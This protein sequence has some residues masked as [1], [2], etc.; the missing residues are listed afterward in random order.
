M[1]RRVVGFGY[2][3]PS[4]SDDDPVSDDQS[5]EGTAASPYA[6]RREANRLPHQNAAAHSGSTP[7]SGLELID[8]DLRFQHFR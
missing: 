5:A 4:S 8:P 1:C 3:V 7:G 6:L 2:A